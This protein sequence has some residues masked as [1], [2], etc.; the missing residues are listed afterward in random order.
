[1][2]VV[3]TFKAVPAKSA[4][5]TSGVFRTVVI[6][7][8]MQHMRSGEGAPVL[9]FGTTSRIR[10]LADT[11][12]K[13]PRTLFELLGDSL[14][15]SICG[16]AAIKRALVLLLLGGLEKNLANGAHLR[17]DINCLMVGDP[18]VA[19]SQLLRAVMHVAPLAISTTGR[20]SSGVGLTAAVTTDGDTGE[21]RLEAGAMGLADGGVVCIDEFDKMS[22][23]DRVAI[24]EV[25]EQ[26]T[27]TI[28]KAGIH[29]S[30]NA[31]CSVVAAANPIYGS[32][33]M[34]LSVTRNVALPD[35]LLSRFDLLF[36]VL[37]QTNAEADREIASHVLRMHAYRPPGDDGANGLDGRGDMEAAAMEEEEVDEAAAKEAGSIFA[38]PVGRGAR[39]RVP[40][41]VAFLKKYISF[42]KNRPRKPQLTTDAADHI[43]SEYAEWRKRAFE[44]R[45]A[46][47]PV[48][49]RTLETMIRLA[50]AHAKMRLGAEVSRADAEAAL[51][52]MRF[53][54]H[55]E[56]VATRRGEAEAETAKAEAKA[57]KE[58]A[59]E[60]AREAARAAG[61]AAA[62]G[63][64]AGTAEGAGAGAAGAG[65]SAAAAPA[66]H[67]DDD[68][69]GFG[70]A[71]A[72]AAAAAAG[73]AGGVAME[74][75]DG[76]GG[77][78]DAAD[79]PA[80]AVDVFNRC[81][82][83]ALTRTDECTVDDVAARMAA[84]GRTL[85]RGQLMA[86]LQKLNAENRIMF[87][88]PNVFKI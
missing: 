1:V 57:A 37:D 7:N 40:L 71:D 8:S 58:A 11:H 12:A 22:D 86:L 29:A 28:A 50:T 51:E 75:D 2:R 31:R 16:H 10:A 70:A 56:E 39:R 64:G 67:D 14:A 77:S 41:S 76:A 73:A 49:A 15:P 44:D 54:L 24:H 27:V 38:K 80:D 9:D 47:L 48:T 17:G 63:S 33:D 53:A 6:G 83:E 72:A 30:L 45:N 88:P 19:K 18:S 59:A 82:V 74:Y 69:D 34:S 13:D 61:G 84:A 35:S 26:Q 43:A 4:A 52:V 68:D 46:T 60:A 32:Y 3:G 79:V 62:G 66:A 65:R 36:V 81:L 55:A 78:D 5:A 23:E 42:A 25:M 21:R 85:R 87:Q 20:G